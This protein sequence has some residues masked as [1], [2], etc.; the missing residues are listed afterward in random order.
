MARTVSTFQT[1]AGNNRPSPSSAPHRRLDRAEGSEL[2]P[3]GWDGHRSLVDNRCC[4]HRGE[5]AAFGALFAF[6]IPNS[7]L[8]TTYWLPWYNNVEPDTRLRFGVP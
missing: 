8:D 3:H 1:L 5:S 2:L 4:M 6:N 7:Q